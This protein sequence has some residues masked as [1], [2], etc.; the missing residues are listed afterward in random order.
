M[1]AQ[2]LAELSSGGSLGMLLETAHLLRS[3]GAAGMGLRLLGAVGGATASHPDVNALRQELAEQPSG[4]LDLASGRARFDANAAALIDHQPWLRPVLEPAAPA[5][6]DR[7]VVY[8][9]RSGNEQVVL[10]Q[11]E[12]SLR[13]V[14]P[15]ADRAEDARRLELDGAQEAG[16]LLLHGT[17]SIA[18]LEKAAGLQAPNGYRPAIDIIE[19]DAQLLRLW[20][21]L[22]DVVELVRREQLFVFAGEK[23]HEQYLRL[24]TQ[25]LDRRDPTHVIH[26]TRPGLQNGAIKHLLEQRVRPAVKAQRQR[27][28]DAQANRYAEM[29]P[30]RWLERYRR[31]GVDEPELRVAAMT[32]RFSTVMQFALRDLAAALKRR[33]IHCDVVMEASESVSGIDTVSLLGRERYDLAIVVNHLRWELDD[34]IHPNLPFVGWVQDYMPA[35]WSKTSAERMTPLDLIVSPS[36]L[37]METVYGYPADQHLES[38]NLTDSHMYHDGE[39]VPELRERF[40]ADAAYVSHGSATPQQ[41]AEEMTQANPQLRTVIENLLGLVR[42]EVEDHGFIRGIT[43]YRICREAL[44]AAGGSADNRAALAELHPIAMTLYDRVLRHQSLEWAAQWARERR[45]TMRI[46]G[47]GWEKHPTLSDFAAGPVENGEPLRA[48]YRCS[49]VNLQINGHN[50]LHQRL[51]DGLACGAFIAT[52]RIPV[53]FYRAAHLRVARRIEATGVTDLDGLFAAAESDDGLADE[54]RALHDLG[55]AGVNPDDPEQRQREREEQVALGAIPVDLGDG[56]GFFDLLRSL[57]GVPRRMAGDL[58]GFAET[59]FGSREELHALLDRAMDDPDWAAG[60]AGRMRACVIRHD[61]FDVLIDR[62]LERLEQRFE[63]LAGGHAS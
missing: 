18:L 45:R 34:Q 47:R 49:T 39:I 26:N 46:Y 3:Q 25:R 14:L 21:H 9:T 43:V 51:L 8:V 35:L 1:I 17:P 33:G 23:A 32:T 41:L 55:V 59:T 58:D 6:E 19:P 5:P 42:A 30:A 38:S 15:Y 11:P 20:L 7:F 48:V 24:R 2:K 57:R 37:Q 44:V 52:R 22:C 62:M 36:T 27:L 16:G 50:S 56:A 40:T 29:T 53:D 13:L 63:T 12:G 4:E 61:T 54:L 60:L 28:L 10:A 31:A